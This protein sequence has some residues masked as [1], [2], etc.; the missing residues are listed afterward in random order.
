MADLT[1][2]TISGYSPTALTQAAGAKKGDEMGQVEFMKLLIAQLKN[3]DPEAPVDSKEFAVQLAQFTQVEKLTSIEQ[4]LASQNQNNISSMAGYLGQQVKL[5]GSEVKVSGGQGG[6]LQIDLTS[7][8]SLVK[9]DLLDADGKVVG[10]K[11]FENLPA[12]KNYVTLDGLGVKDGG[13]GFSVS[14]TRPSGAGFYQPPA[15]VS[16]LVT[17]FVPGPDPKLVIGN[18][19]YPVGAVQE[20]TL[21]QKV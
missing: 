18:Q 10:T 5:S 7:A 6:Q 1:T 17:G 8:S 14:A 15:S 13:Y 11:T 20:V 4:K 12:G 21:P 9:V 16:G 19:E 3:Q 2:G